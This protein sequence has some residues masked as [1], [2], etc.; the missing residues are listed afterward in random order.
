MLELLVKFFQS[1]GIDYGF[2]RLLNYL[3]FRAIMGMS[4][5]LVFTLVFGFRFIL[6]LYKKKLRDTS[7]DFLSIKV[8]SKRGTPTGGG[9]LIIASTSI[10]VLLWADITNIFTH[11]LLLGFVYTGL[12]GFL[13]DLQKSQSRSSL[14]GLSQLAKTILLLIFIIPFTMF[15]LSPL[16]PIP[17][18]LKTLI[19]IPFYK[20]PIIDL[21]SFIFAIFMV[22]VMFSITNA[23]NITDGMDGLLSGISSL[24]IGVYSVFAYVI[25][26]AIASSHYLF[27][28]IKNAGE[29][30]VFG[31]SLIGALLGFMWF[32]T[33]P[34]QVF[35]GDTGSLAIG[36]AISMIVFFTKQELLFLVVGGVLVIEIFS[37]LVQ[38]KIGNRLGRR[39]FY[40]A[41]FHYSLTHTG[42][43]EPKAVVRLW[44]ISIL[45]ALIALL[46]LKVR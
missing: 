26:N 10:S 17:T 22:F 40:R 32:N 3:T 13:D 25:G 42:V 2:F 37:S 34:A 20:Y 27:P 19:Y 16:N 12:V 9:I 18:N 7:G 24:T 38:E 46:S 35:M 23:V 31:A 39:I 36:A 15:Y 8:Y 14:S 43:A 4:T 29:I 28:Y 45:L 1:S 30:T 11:V 5:A 6:Y 44:I 21:S 33:Y 41:P